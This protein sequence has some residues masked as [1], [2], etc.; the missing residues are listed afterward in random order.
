MVM[1]RK[2]DKPIYPDYCFL[3]GQPD[4]NPLFWR[5]EIYSYI[6]IEHK[7]KWYLQYFNRSMEIPHFVP[8]ME[9]HC[10]MFD[11]LITT[12]WAIQHLWIFPENMI[13][14]MSGKPIVELDKDQRS[15]KERLSQDV[16]CWT[17]KMSIQRDH[18]GITGNSS[19]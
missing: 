19:K 7:G 10:L 17:Q 2:T 5:Y 15:E 18:P 6:R 16:F 1:N 3:K 14:P 11:L 13:D 12:T 8:D 9:A 4:D